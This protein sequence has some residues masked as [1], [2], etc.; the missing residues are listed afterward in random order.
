MA[1]PVLIVENSQEYLQLMAE[2]VE[3]IGY[4]ARQA[5]SAMQAWKVLEQEEVA[6]V[7]L[8]IKMPQ[9]HGHQFLQYMRKRGKEVPVIAVSGFL[10][11]EIIE[12]LREHQ[13]RQIIVKPF[14][15]QRLAQEVVQV[16]EGERA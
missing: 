10:T 8:D 15:V 14:K 11:P 13:V 6:L 9:V 7:L 2:I 16:L 12:V 4:Q 1:R 5:H 3:G